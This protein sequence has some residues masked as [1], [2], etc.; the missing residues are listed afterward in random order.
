MFIKT[1]EPNYISYTY[2]P[3]F[4]NVFNFIIKSGF[5]CNVADP[6][7]LIPIIIFIDPNKSCLDPDPLSKGKR[8]ITLFCT[9][10]NINCVDWDL[11]IGKP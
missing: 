1:K 3:E 7:P 6:D 11:N 2:I 4:K 10:K 8:R 9:P 5:E